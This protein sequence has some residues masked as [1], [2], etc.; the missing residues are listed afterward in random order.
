M[1]KG[2]NPPEAVTVNIIIILGVGVGL[3][4]E[5]AELT[6]VKVKVGVS[7]RVAVGRTSPPLTGISREG[8]GEKNSNAKASLVNARSIGVAVAVL[9]G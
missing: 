9:L 5:V 2:L 6:G 4:V 8:V 3:S 7:A 1:G